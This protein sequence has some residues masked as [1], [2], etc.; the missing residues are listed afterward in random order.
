MHRL[1]YAVVCGALLFASGYAA[2]RETIRVGYFSLVPHI[3]AENGKNRGAVVDLWESYIAPAMGVDIV[4]VGPLPPVR[5]FTSLR[6]GDINALALFA[7]NDERLVLYDWA[8]DSFYTMQAGVA[9]L[10]T[11]KLERISSVDDLAHHTI[12]FFKDGLIPPSL[13]AV[14]IEWDLVTM[15]DW[16]RVNLDKLLSGRIDAAFDANALSLAT[17]VRQLGLED[18]VKVLT[19]PDT[20][21]D[22]F[23]AFSKAD[24]GRFLAKY[25]AATK[26]INLKAVYLELLGRYR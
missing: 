1:R 7:K 26:E 22:E 9:V 8:D 17:V 13:D 4:W 3:Y 24:N 16:S 21:A 15:P 25:N 12:G 20:F 2:A 11:D 23:A 18:K 6:T 14:P 19:V 10:K 5:A